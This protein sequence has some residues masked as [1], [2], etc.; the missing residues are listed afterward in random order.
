MIHEETKVSLD[1]LHDKSDAFITWICPFLKPSHACA[2]QE[3][4]SQSN[5]INQIYFLKSGEA[6]FVLPAK[7]NSVKYI[8]IDI[9]ATFGVIDI[10]GSCLDAAE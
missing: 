3:I 1:F 2:G 7:Y 4:Y 9:G 5:D 6:G 8:D 10:V